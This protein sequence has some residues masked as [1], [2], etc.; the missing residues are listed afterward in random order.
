MSN[1]RLQMN[2]NACFMRWWLLNAILVLVSI[3]CYKFGLFGEIYRK[4]SSY[5]CFAIMVLYVFVTAY[6]GN[7]ITKGGKKETILED[8]E[9]VWFMSELCLSLGMVGTVIGFIQMLAGFS[10][11]NVSNP[12][13]LQNMIVAMSFGMSTALYTTLVG[14]I[15]GNLLKLQAFDINRDCQ[16][17]KDADENK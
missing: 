14:L 1:E 6:T 15:F 7:L 13:S 3:I 4:D 9:F 16:I 5:L 11:I 10:T 8:L 17:K 2:K 12:T